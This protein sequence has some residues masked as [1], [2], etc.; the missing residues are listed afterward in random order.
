M[1][2]HAPLAGAY[3][4]PDATC[5]VAHAAFPHGNVYIHLRD[6][7]GML[8]ENH[9]FAHLFAHDGQP[10][11]APARLALVLIFQFLEDLSDRQA[12][13]AVRDRISWK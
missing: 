12:A 13:A 2:M 7:F 8:Y 9:R 11:L 10:A 3:H 1:R 6:R 5:Q 4:I